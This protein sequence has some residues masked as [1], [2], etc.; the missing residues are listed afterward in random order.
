[1]HTFA[2]PY[3]D[4]DEVVEQIVGSC[5][6]TLG[7]TC[8]SDLLHVNDAPLSLPRIEVEGSDDLAAFVHKLTV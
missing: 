1:V 4:R 3:G 7:F 2:Y 5:G 6:V 8:R